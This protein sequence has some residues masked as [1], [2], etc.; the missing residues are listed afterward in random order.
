MRRASTPPTDR[1]RSTSWPKRAPPRMPRP[2][3][4]PCRPSS[5]SAKNARP[6][7]ARTDRPGG[8]MSEAHDWLIRAADSLLSQ[9]RVETTEGFVRLHGESSVD[10]AEGIRLLAP[11]VS[12][13]RA[14]ARRAQSVNNLKQI[15]LAFHNYNQWPTIS[16]RRSIAAARTRSIPYSWRVAILPYHRAAGAL[17]P[18]QLR[19]AVGRPEQSQADRQDAG[20]LRPSRRWMERRRAG[21]TRR[22]SSSRAVD[23]SGAPEASRRSRR[24]PTARPTQSWPSRRSARSPGPSPRTSPSTRKPPCPSWAGSR[25]TDSMPCSRDGS[26]RYIKKSINPTVLK[27][28][29]TRDGGEVVSSDSLLSRS[30]A[31]S[32][33]PGEPGPSRVGKVPARSARRTPGYAPSIGIVVYWTD[34]GPE[35]AESCPECERRIPPGVTSGR[36]SDVRRMADDVPRDEAEATSQQPV[37]SC[38]YPRHARFA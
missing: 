8:A 17:Q 16:P 7:H 4:R 1:W 28:L 24:S 23:G 15:G 34:S 35:T 19:R 18:V 31:P 2:W 12:A 37:R 9:A 3:P 5:P 6:G 13:A 21:A 33:V 26:V 29:I 11:A 14:A 27:A 10:I 20:D 25:R 32:G 38:W 36:Q 22:T 30:S